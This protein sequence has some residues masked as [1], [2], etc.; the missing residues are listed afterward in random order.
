MSGGS[1]S[2]IMSRVTLRAV[3]VDDNARFRD[4]VCRL[5]EAEG[6]AVVGQAADGA[7]ALREVAR[8]SPDVVLLD[9]GLPD[10]SGLEV[11][12]LLRSEDQNWVVILISTREADLGRRLAA[13]VAASYL[14]KSDLS[15][16]AI[17]RLV[18]AGRCR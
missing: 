3:V 7:G 5:L 17:A 2:T 6:I 13:G 8:T 14:P 1:P 12:R 10:A 9:I 18:S 11:A 4:V 15:G 16:A